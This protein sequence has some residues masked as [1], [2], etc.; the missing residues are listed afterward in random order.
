MTPDH[1]EASERERIEFRFGPGMNY[2][3]CFQKDGK[4]YVEGTRG[5]CIEPTA[6]NFVQ[7]VFRERD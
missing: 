6:S 2:I 7:I 5:F 4:L 3:T 1:Y